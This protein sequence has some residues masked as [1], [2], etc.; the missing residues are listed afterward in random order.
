M[1]FRKPAFI[2][3]AIA[4]AASVVSAAEP[5]WPKNSASEFSVFVT[6]QRY[7]IYAD[8]CSAR[9]PEA[10]PGFEAQMESLSSRIQGIS[11]VL[12]ASDAFSGMKDKPVPAEIAFAL[13]DAMHDTEHNLERQD[14]AFICP[15][16]LQRFAKLDDE[17]LKSGLL[18]IL[19]A[20]Q[21]M[22]R[23]LEKEDAR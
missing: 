7:R 16:T 8:H 23:N 11:K 1:N 14:A 19:T 2:A 13:K 6:L 10:K 3:P 5:V 22:I 20:V 21:K 15:G 18:E 17:S 12:L 4:L 9:I